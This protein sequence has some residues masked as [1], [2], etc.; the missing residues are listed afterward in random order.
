M[1]Y[2]YYVSFRQEAESGILY[3]T[4][5]IEVIAITEK[6]ALASALAAALQRRHKHDRIVKIELVE[7]CDNMGM[8]EYKKGED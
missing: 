1:H 4:E 5:C 7:I 3:D 8:T 6:Q 2:K